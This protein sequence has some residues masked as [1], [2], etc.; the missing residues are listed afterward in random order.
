MGFVDHDLDFEAANEF[1][2]A[3]QDLKQDKPVT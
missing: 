3:T 2:P 1:L